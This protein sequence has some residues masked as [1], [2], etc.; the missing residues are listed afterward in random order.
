MKK[1]INVIKTI[2]ERSG[3]LGSYLLIV[4]MLMSVA[5]V[6]CRSLLR[7]AIL[8]AYEY[9]V[10]LL[11]GAAFLGFGSCTLHGEHVT[12]DLII[13]LLPKKVKSFLGHLDNYLTIGVAILIATR[14][15]V[16]ASIYK[17][18]DIVFPITG[19]AKYPFLLVIALGYFLLLLAVILK[20]FYYKKEY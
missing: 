2:I 1:V 10:M 17:G 7:I 19:V 6:I 4:M 12:V 9:C 5:D 14:C 18:T 8:G 15:I 13:G 20:E 16:Q 11:I 3:L